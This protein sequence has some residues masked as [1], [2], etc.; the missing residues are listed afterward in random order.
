M[1]P[2]GFYE[3]KESKQ[4]EFRSASAENF[5]EEMKEIHNQ[6]KERLQSSN[7]EYKHKADQ[8]R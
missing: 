5:A 7:Q 6:V 8:H 2:R 4:N 3:L 1:Q